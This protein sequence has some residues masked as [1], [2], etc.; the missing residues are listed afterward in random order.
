MRGSLGV[1]RMG[2]VMSRAL[3]KIV[4]VMVGLLGLAASPDLATAATVHP[5]H[6]HTYDGHHTYGQPADVATD[7]A[8]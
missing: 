6:A 5:I 3:P 2:D 8:N 4:A 7:L 1:F